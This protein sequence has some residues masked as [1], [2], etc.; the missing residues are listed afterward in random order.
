MTAVVRK[1]EERDLQS[2]TELDLTYP[3]GRYLEIRRS[4]AE[5][6]QTLTLRWQERESPDALYAEYS[7][8]RLEM[9]L[10]ERADLFLVAELDGRVAGML[11][12]LVPE[13]TDAAEI[14]DLAEGCGSSAR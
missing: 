9:A 8:D 10:R 6:E 4:G 11:I 1:A 12:V 2:L 7:V 14:T 3:T 5:P 13:W